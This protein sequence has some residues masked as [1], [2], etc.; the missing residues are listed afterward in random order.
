M[1]KERL[2]ALTD[3]IYAIAMTILVL[4]LPLP[5]SSMELE[6]SLGIIL[7]SVVDYGLTFLL[8]FGFWYNQRRINELIE[9]HS[10]L[11]LWL[12]ALALML[13][14]LLPF[15]ATLLYRIGSTS[16][17]LSSMSYSVFVDLLF[18]AICLSAD[19]LIH[20][21]LWLIGRYHAENSESREQV[22]RI[23]QSRQIATVV[24]V[25]AMFISLIAPGPNRNTLIMI[26]LLLI[27]EDEVVK[28]VS[29][30][31]H[32]LSYK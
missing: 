11:T 18:V 19:I 24:V 7:F 22:K 5:D 30:I 25:I 13:V 23:T 2:G 6:E 8:L 10:R 15:S 27:F 1:N 16:S 20:T 9:D 28:I 31:R 4:E 21:I 12:N 29:W 14:C 17:S 3:G 26:P 32:R